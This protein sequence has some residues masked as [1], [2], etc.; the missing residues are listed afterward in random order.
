EAQLA[1]VLSKGQL[2]SA[3]ASDDRSARRVTVAQADATRSS[4]PASPPSFFAKLFGGNN[5]HEEPESEAA[6]AP[7]QTAPAAPNIARAAMAARSPEKKAVAEKVAAVPVPQARPV[8]PEGYQVA[9]AGSTPVKLSEGFQVASA[10]STSVRLAQLTPPVANSNAQVANS[11]APNAPASNVISDRGNW[12]GPANAEPAENTQTTVTRTTAGSR[13]PAKVATANA[14]PWP[15]VERKSDDRAPAVGALS[16]APQPALPTRT[17][18]NTRAPAAAEAAAAA[19]VA[20][21]PGDELLSAT[22]RKGPDVVQ[23]GDRF[24]DPWM[25][26][27]M[28]SPNAQSFLK[29]TLYGSPDFRNLGPLFA[30]PSSVVVMKFTADPT[31][32]V[33]ADKFSGNSVG[34]TP[35]MNFMPRTA[36][37]R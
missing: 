8:K 31:N 37:L 11:P 17:A 16:Y 13:T 29:I 32:G 20:V 25:R 7:V 19:A 18:N 36:S 23:V 6:A 27:M 12:Q 21:K 30:K 2:A 26:A 14:A 24:N 22:P 34:F 5:D 1:K 9:S 33:S 4:A 15:I 3:N 28:L 35:I 10:G